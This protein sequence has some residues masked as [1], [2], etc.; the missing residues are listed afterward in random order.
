[1]DQNQQTPKLDLAQRVAEALR[2]TDEP[3]HTVEN[4]PEDGAKF[5]GEVP[6]HL[7]HLHNLMHDLHQ[8]TCA[9]SDPCVQYL[10]SKDYSIVH[11]LFFMSLRTHTP[12]PKG[13]AII[14]VEN[15]KVYTT[16]PSPLTPSGLL[17]ALLGGGSVQVFVAP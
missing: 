2:R 3:R 16:T 4:K 12:P 14:L 13:Y 7:R 15:W 8:E 1:M 10:R 6:V 11:E 5:L 9:E 17:S